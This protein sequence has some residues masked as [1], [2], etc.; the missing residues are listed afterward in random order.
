MQVVKPLRVVHTIASLHPRGGGTTR[1][2]V[3]LTDSLAENG[4]VDV[5]LMTQSKFG[6][7]LCPG[8][9][10]DVRRLVPMSANRLSLKFGLP[11]MRS[12]TKLTQREDFDIIH[13]HGVWLPI[14]YWTCDAGRRL[15]LPVVL[16]PHGMLEPWALMHKS[17]KKRAALAIFQRRDLEGAKIFIATAQKEYENIRLLGMKQPIAVIPNGV[18]SIPNE[19]LEASKKEKAVFQDMHTVLFLSRV[20]PVKGLINLLHAWATV[21]PSGWRLE[22]AGPNECGHLDEVIATVARLGIQ[23]SVEYLG[24]IEGEVKARA[25]GRADLFVLPTFSENFGVVV[26]EALAH[27]IP[28]ITT[29]GAPWADLETFDCGWWVD[30][31]VD[32]L[33]RALREGMALSDD[34]RRAMGARGRE[35]VRRYDWDDIAQQTIDVYRWVLGQGPQPGCVRTD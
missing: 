33:V 18:F 8:S 13:S 26:A 4:L 3:D 5:T 7:E 19:S 11:F 25:Y 30:I 24:E 9:I 31:G 34:E 21:S 17:L 27:G 32:P 28:V 16:Q 22:I 35:Y 15:G 23:S 2:A 29:R 10:S 6:E 20:H 1:V 14:N 12:L